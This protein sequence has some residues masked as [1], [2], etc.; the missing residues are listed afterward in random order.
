MA[1]FHKVLEMGSVIYVVKIF[2]AGPQEKWLKR[3]F[4]SSPCLF[5]FDLYIFNAFI[6][7]LVLFPED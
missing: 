5:T 1:K 3:G 6:Y 7:S 4:D 2:I